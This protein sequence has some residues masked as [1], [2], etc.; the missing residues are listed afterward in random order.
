M[1]STPREDLIEKLKNLDFKRAFGAEQAK[2]EIGALLHKT[3]KDFNLTQKE[4]SQKLEISQPYIAR[5]EAGEANPTISAIGRMLAV[6]NLRLAA[7]VRPIIHQSATDTFISNRQQAPTNTNNSMNVDWDQFIH[8]RPKSQSSRSAL[9]GDW[10]Q[11][12][13]VQQNDRV[14]LGV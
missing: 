3:R 1:N 10:C 5:L 2:L 13:D 11:P 6:L 12:E 7:N 9:E 14:L 4:L 8:P